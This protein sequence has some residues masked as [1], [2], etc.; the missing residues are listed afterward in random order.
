MFEQTRK[1]RAKHRI[2]HEDDGDD[3]QRPAHRAARG[4]EQQYDQRGAHDHVE[5]V[6]VANAKRQIVKHVGDVERRGD[7]RDGAKPVVERQT[8]RV[9]PA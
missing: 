6:R 4:L 3:R 2:E 1:H 8:E 9:V 5:R 7:G